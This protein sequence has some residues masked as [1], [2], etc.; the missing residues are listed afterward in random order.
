M[1][2]GAKN[3][4]IPNTNSR[5]KNLLILIG[6]L[7][8][9]AILVVVVIHFSLSSCTGQY[10]YHEGLCDTTTTILMLGL[11]M[12]IPIIYVGVPSLLVGIVIVGLGYLI[13]RVQKSRLKNDTNKN[14]SI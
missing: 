9:L 4:T 11:L 8:F 13:K 1:E 10:F 5:K 3:N 7:S 2:T 12:S 6:S 14:S